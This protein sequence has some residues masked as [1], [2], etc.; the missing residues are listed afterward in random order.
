MHYGVM[1][2]RFIANFHQRPQGAQV[3]DE[4]LT[5]LCFGVGSKSANLPVQEMH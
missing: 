3:N 4:D 2:G 1:P 5:G